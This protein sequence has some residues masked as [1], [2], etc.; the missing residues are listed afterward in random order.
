MSTR[1][2]RSTPLIPAAV[3]VVGLLA[4]GA[5]GAGWVL[6]LTQ[7]PVQEVQL[8]EIPDRFVQIVLDRPESD[9]R[10]SPPGTA[11]SEPAHEQIRREHPNPAPEAARVQRVEPQQVAAETTTESS[12]LMA[13]LSSNGLGGAG[14]EDLFAGDGGGQNLE[15]ALAAVSGVDVGEA[16][17]LSNVG[18]RIGSIDASAAPD[19]VSNT[20]NYTDYGINEL[21]LAEQDRHSTFSIDVDTASYS[22]SRRKLQSGT[23]P[24]TSSVRVEEFVNYF[25]YEYVG[26]TGDAP[27]A[28][29][30]EA[31]PN[32]F[33]P[34]RHVMRVGVQ[35]R[36]PS[37]DR[38]PIHLTFLVDTSGS[39]SSA[40]KIGLAQQS[41]HELVENL[42]PTDTVALAT[43]AGSVRRVLAPTPARH[44]A[45]IHGAIDELRAGGSTAMSSGIDL[46]YEMASAAAGRGHERRVIVLSDGDANV[47]ATSHDSILKK[48]DHYAEEGIT[49][50]TI[51]FGMGNYKDTMMEQLAN[52]G[53]GNYFYIDSKE[54]AEKVFGDDL[55]GTLEVIAKDV[56]IQV[57]FNPDAVIAYRLIGYEN[58][59]IADKDFR[60]DAVDAGEI[61]AGHSVTALYDVVLKDSFQEDALATVRLRSKPPGPDAPSAEWLT[62]FPSRLVHRKY[63]SAGQDF[64][65]AFVA[66]SFAELLRGSP[67]TAEIGYGELSRM[68]ASTDRGQP[69]DQEL[70]QLIGLA[71]QLSGELAQAVR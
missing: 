42:Q 57:E 53:D 3:G 47:G 17:G 15:A 65:V 60:N 71:G 45:R 52:K 31:A 22:I 6:H 41:L 12:L 4:L 20:E 1:I 28:V 25:P 61:G 33:M 51:G 35:G 16:G 37:A 67:Y 26:P 38:D 44:A 63:A 34:G 29:N 56:K 24:P 30:M 50:S 48:I 14:S 70:G 18:A 49:L 11:L 58:R 46:A 2:P 7:Q 68:L 10:Q 36:A 23:L 64:Q 21:V 32:P 62:T 8:Q 69:S 43:Y 19:T 13:L 40:D 39:M 66:A 55:G 59:D 5:V 9:K 54:E 27:F